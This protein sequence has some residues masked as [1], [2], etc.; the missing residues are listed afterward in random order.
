MSYPWP[1]QKVTQALVILGL[2]LCLLYSWL[3]HRARGKQQGFVPVPTHV[4][5]HPISPR[6]RKWERVG[7]VSSLPPPLGYSR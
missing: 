3:P 4:R 7:V 2:H 6:I 1:G 5:S